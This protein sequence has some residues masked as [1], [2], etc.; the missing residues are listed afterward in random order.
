MVGNQNNN[1]RNI[2]VWLIIGLVVLALVN[3]LSART[4]QVATAEIPISQVVEDAKNGR[5]ENVTFQGSRVSGKYRD[6]GKQFTS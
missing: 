2:V 4:P 3:L 6:T 1:L 5:I